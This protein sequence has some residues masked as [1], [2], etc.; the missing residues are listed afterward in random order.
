[1]AF[2]VTNSS[3]SFFL[4]SLL[5]DA[6]SGHREVAGRLDLDRHDGLEHAVVSCQVVDICVAGH[7]KMDRCIPGMY[8]QGRVWKSHLVSSDLKCYH[9]RFNDA[10]DHFVLSFEAL[11]THPSRTI[12]DRTKVRPRIGMDVHVTVQQI[13]GLEGCSITT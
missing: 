11:T 2:C 12:F 1:M 9:Y 7:C 8:E 13:L 4:G 6:G 5:Q 10:P 3:V